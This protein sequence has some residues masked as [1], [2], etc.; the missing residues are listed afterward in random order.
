MSLGTFQEQYPVPPPGR[1]RRLS[2]QSSIPEGEDH[3]LL[4][5]S[6]IPEEEPDEEYPD[7]AISEAD[8]GC[9]TPRTDVSGFSAKTR[10]RIRKEVAPIRGQRPS[11]L[12]EFRAQQ[13]RCKEV[14]RQGASRQMS[15]PV[16][17]R[18]SSCE[19]MGWFSEEGQLADPLVGVVRNVAGQ[20]SQAYQRLQGILGDAR[21]DAA[22]HR[23]EM[24]ELLRRQACEIDE[25]RRE[26]KRCR[27]LQ[28]VKTFVVAFGL[29]LGVAS[30][31]Q[32]ALKVAGVPLHP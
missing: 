27:C 25:L 5:T 23:Q 30:A 13:Q 22:L 31:L 20:Q 2:N 9:M 18:Q 28:V 32:S 3:G 16:P 12:A 6:S 15:A 11:T 17:T 14:L 4:D 29:S 24:M 10:E 1:T 7:A 19:S 8:T 26:R 21:E